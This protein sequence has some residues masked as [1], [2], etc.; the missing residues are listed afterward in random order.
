[1]KPKEVPFPSKQQGKCRPDFRLRRKAKLM[2]RLNTALSLLGLMLCLTPTTQAQ[3]APQEQP[4]PAFPQ[5]FPKPSGNNGYEE[6]VM[7]G[8]LARQHPLLDAASSANATLADKRRALADP[9]I[10]RAIELIRIGMNKP[11]AP[12]QRG[13]LDENTTFPEFAGFRALARLIGVHIYV[14]LADGQINP[15]LDDL[16]AILRLGYHVQSEAFI[17]GLVG[18]AIDSIGLVSIARH[19]PQ[20]SVRDCDRLLLMMRQ[21]LEIPAPELQVIASERDS[22]VNILRKGR[23]DKQKLYQLFA[24]ITPDMEQSNPPSKLQKAIANLDTDT[25]VIVDGAIEKIVKLY[26]AS[27]AN[28]KLPFWKRTKVELIDDRSLAY[29]LAEMITMSPSVVSD[30]YVNIQ[31]QLHLLATHAAIRKFRWE[32]DRLPKSLDELKRERDEGLLTDPFTGEFL[33]YKPDGETYELYSTG[34]PERDADGKIIS[35]SGKRL[36]LPPPRR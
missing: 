36:Y 1:V 11:I 19:I 4:P 15:A 21:W 33:V 7:A 5:L 26:D 30:R 20:F 10:R 9:Q 24:I 2:K 17:S 14:S 31:A 8:D 35:G 6:F 29:D 25:S 12:M 18:I 16:Q 32:H 28:L 22:I 3:D 13:E 23:N 27:L 34:I